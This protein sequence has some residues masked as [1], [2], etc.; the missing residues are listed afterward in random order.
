MPADSPEA[1]L[2]VI[3]QLNRKRALG[4]STTRRPYLSAADRPL[5]L[6]A[7]QGEQRLVTRGVAAIRVEMRRPAYSLRYA[8]LSTAKPCSAYRVAGAT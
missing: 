1:C 4:A 6:R 7:S 5:E 8:A 3:E 2:A